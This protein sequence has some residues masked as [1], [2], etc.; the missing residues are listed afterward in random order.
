MSKGVTTDVQLRQLAKRMRIPYFRGVFMRTT[1]PTEGIRGN[2]S[3]IINL[4][5]AKGSG[6]HWV[7]Y[8]KKG[9]RALYFDSFGNLRP[10]KELRYLENNVTQIE[11]NRTPR[12]CYHQSNCVCSFYRR[13][14][15][16]L[17][18]DI[19]LLNSVFI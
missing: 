12:Q 13:L 6:T 1:L 16:N 4:D 10:S 18:T 9:N 19:A 3:G 14:T 8:A 15:I 7:A 5:N 11:Y 17:R 2:K